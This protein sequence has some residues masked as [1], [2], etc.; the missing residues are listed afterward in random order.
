MHSRIPHLVRLAP[1]AILAVS[2]LMPLSR[3]QVGTA[4][5][6]ANAKAKSALRPKAALV[7]DLAR[8]DNRVM[9]PMRFLTNSIGPRLTGSRSLVAACE[10]AVEQFRSYGLS[11]AHLEKWGEVPV[12]FERGP[13]FGA[14]QW[15]DG[16]SEKKRV[17]LEFNTPAWSAGTD[18]L[19]KG[20]AVLEPRDKAS[21]LKI[22][23][24]LRGAWLIARPRSARGSARANGSARRGR[25]RAPNR[26]APLQPGLERN[27]QAKPFNVRQA[28]EEA[29][30]RGIVK[31]SGGNYL[32]TSSNR[33]VNWRKLSMER[34]PTLVQVSLV[35]RQYE[36]ALQLLESGKDLELEFQVQNR[37]RK[38]PVPLYNVVA[39]LPGTER[40]D[41]FVLVGG[42][43]DCWDGANGAVDN[44]SGVS[45][46]MEAARLLARAGVR[47]KRTIRFVLWSG[48]EQ[49]LLGSRG[50]VKAHKDELARTSVY[51]NHDSGTNYVAGAPATP[52]MRAA[53]EEALAGISSIDPEFPFTLRTSK[54]LSGRGSD[55]GSF[56]AA[57]VPAWSWP[58]KGEHNYRHIWHT[59]F[60]NADQIIERYQ[61]HSATVIAVAALGIADLPKLLS[62]EKLRAQG[63]R[64][65]FNPGIRLEGLIV[66]S[67]RKGSAFEEAGFQKGDQLISVAGSKLKDRRSLYMA[68]F[69]AGGKAVEVTVKRG[70]EEK[71][72]QLTFDIRRAMRRR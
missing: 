22:R 58:L 8:K 26:P 13:W 42:H 66:Q 23:E 29:G 10:W 55:H 38:G 18:G 33:R 68:L 9:E 1:S 61:R 49:G 6:R 34:L 53:L 5:A 11:N 43:I 72:L 60:D 2:V 44:A 21:F 15:S 71:K 45:T 25:R 50:Y 20:P 14:M 31:S 54:G 27:R 35:A 65:G 24:K 41:E 59:Q 56:L 63:G 69:R 62:R 70:T 46:A 57:G 32:R 16:T 28:C 51:L 52:A 67:L 12:A 37:F 48:E 36:Q 19:R 47:G 17:V 40:P 4:E 3:A 39:E 7:V 30:I 64:R